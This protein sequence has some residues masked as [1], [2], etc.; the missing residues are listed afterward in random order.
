MSIRQ[1]LVVVN[2]ETDDVTIFAAVARVPSGMSVQILDMDADNQIALKLVQLFTGNMRR[3]PH[4]S[5]NLFRR[6]FE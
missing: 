5:L 2:D 6:W 1:Y 3:L 4:L